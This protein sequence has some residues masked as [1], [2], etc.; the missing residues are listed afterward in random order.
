[1]GLSFL[2]NFFFRHIFF[3]LKTTYAEAGRELVRGEKH[4]E[5][6]HTHTEEK[7]RAD[8]DLVEPRK[9]TFI[10]QYTF[11]EKKSAKNYSTYQ[12]WHAR[13]R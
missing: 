6:P 4:C 9:K 10:L 11:A 13:F 7:T 5:R 12:A 3:L 8:T 2:L 1:M